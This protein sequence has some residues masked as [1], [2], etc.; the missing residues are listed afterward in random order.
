MTCIVA[1]NRKNR[2]A[3]L[4]EIMIALALG[5]LIMLGVTQI[6]TDN[7]STRNELERFGRQLETANYALGVIEADVTNA[8]FWGERGGYDPNHVAPICPDDATELEQAMGYPIQGG[9]GTITCSP[10]NLVTKAN[11]DYLAV[12][13]VS[14]CANGSTGCDAAAGDY[15]LQV[16]ACFDATSPLQ[17]GDTF[18]IDT[19]L[20][21]LDLEQRDCTNQ[22]PKY[23]FLS[24]IYYVDADD[25]LIRAELVGNQYATQEL[26]ENV[27]M[28]RFE[29]G[30]D[31]DD[32]GQVDSYMSDVA[33]PSDASWPNVVMV[34]VGL[35]VRNHQASLGFNDA[36]NYTVGGYNYDPP[37]AVEDFRRQL[38]TRTIS[39]RNIAGRKEN[40]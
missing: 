26:A 23:R 28:L 18:K 10:A 40:P 6:A 30:L 22:A 8:A 1:H 24:R 21:N 32:D 16:H 36:R 27:E 34:R 33:D 25:K 39:T 31:T 38:Y 29:Y 3:G 4:I 11:T 19:D 20:T 5:A 37:A 14:S 13:R 17:P 9:Q 2:G 7:S 15:H 12:R 35:V